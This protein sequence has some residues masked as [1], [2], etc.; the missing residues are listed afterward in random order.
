MIIRIKRRDQL[1]HH[2]NPSQQILPRSSYPSKSSCILS[3]SLLPSSTLAFG[4]TQPTPFGQPQNQQANTGGGLFGAQPQ[5]QPAQ[6]S[7]FTFGQSTNQAQSQAPVF[8]QQP[9]PTGFGGF[10]ATTGGNNTGGGFTFGEF[11]ALQVEARLKGKR[12]RKRS[13]W[14][15]DGIL[16]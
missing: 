6:S 14:W 8:G 4:Q 3:T 15:S 13:S 12:G 1:D 11:V 7:G 5:A 9:K 2:A 16:S 10:G